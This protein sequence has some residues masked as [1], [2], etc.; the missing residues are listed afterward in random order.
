MGAEVLEERGSRASALPSSSRWAHQAI[1]QQGCFPAE[2]ASVSP[3]T[4]IV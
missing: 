1:P 4:V 3:G 2:P